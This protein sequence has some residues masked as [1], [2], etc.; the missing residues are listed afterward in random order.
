MNWR[1]LKSSADGFEHNWPRSSG[2]VQSRSVARAHIETHRRKEKKKFNDHNQAIV[3]WIDRRRHALNARHGLQEL[4]G[5][6]ACRKE[7]QYEDVVSDR[8]VY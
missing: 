7:S 6:A 5:H 8:P 4:P 3:G 1:E 2:R